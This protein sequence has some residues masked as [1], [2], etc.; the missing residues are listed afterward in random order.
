M[1]IG[2]IGSTGLVGKHIIKLLKKHNVPIKKLYTDLDII[3]QTKLDIVLLAT[4]AHVSKQYASILKADYVIDNSNQFRMEKDI[5]LIVPEINSHLIPKYT[6]LNSPTI[7]SNPNCSTAQLVMGIYPLHNKYIIKRMVISTYQSVSGS[8]KKGIQQ[9]NMEANN[10]IIE[11]N[12]PYIHTIHKNCIPCCDIMQENGYTLEELKLINE[13]SK[14]LES[15][16]SITATAVRIPVEG[17]HSESVNIE[18][19]KDFDINEVKQLLKNTEGIQL[20]DYPTPLD[21]HNQEDVFIG[22]IRRDLSQPNTLNMWIVAD[23]LMKGAA[24]NAIQ[25][26]EFIYKKFYNK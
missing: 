10:L 18:F 16:I 2:I 5:P 22:R 8:G 17:G 15:D 19:E 12:S 1:N 4:P 26:V 7:I 9:L 21:V 20:M 3:L 23:N 11:T 6:S 25:I 14:I 13:T 24:L